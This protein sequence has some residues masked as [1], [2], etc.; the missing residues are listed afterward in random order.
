MS[1]KCETHTE[2]VSTARA[3]DIAVE[4][5]DRVVATVREYEEKV[6]ETFSDVF[7]GVNF[8]AE[9]SRNPIKTIK[10]LM[11]IAGVSI[12]DLHQ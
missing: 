2:C 11:L 9:L 12:E 10:R 7:R 5:R 8:P 1:K 6:A 4:H 3:H